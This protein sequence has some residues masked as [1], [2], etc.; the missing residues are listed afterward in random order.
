MH[1]YI[2]NLLEQVQ[3]INLGMASLE[4]NAAVNLAAGEAKSDQISEKKSR[5]KVK[6]VSGITSLSR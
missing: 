2:D 6:N 5:F 3:S 1:A 4:G